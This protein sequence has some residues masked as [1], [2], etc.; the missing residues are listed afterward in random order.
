VHDTL[1]RLARRYLRRVFAHDSDVPPRR[2]AVEAGLAIEPPAAGVTAGEVVRRD[3][4]VQLGRVA[5]RRL[6]VHPDAW[7]RAVTLDRQ[8]LEVAVLAQAGLAPRG[9]V[10]ERAAVAGTVPASSAAS[11]YSGPSTAAAAAEMR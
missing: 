1:A 9:G 3:V 2:V 11:A 10:R 4:V 6:V 5:E 8:I 7:K